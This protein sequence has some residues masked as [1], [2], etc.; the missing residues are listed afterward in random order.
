PGGHSHS[1]PTVAVGIFLLVLLAAA[2]GFGAAALRPASVTG[3]V[4]SWY[5]LLTGSLVTA[6]NA[7][8]LVHGVGRLELAAVGLAAAVFAIAAW[9][10]V[11][12]PAIPRLAIHWCAIR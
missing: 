5:L 8:S 11:G 12:R 2:S 9:H 4:L 7:L 10:V 3:F 6:L 1:M